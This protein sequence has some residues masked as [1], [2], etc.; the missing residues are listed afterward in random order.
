MAAGR[1]SVN[2]LCNRLGRCQEGNQHSRE[3]DRGRMSGGVLVVQSLRR[4]QDVKT[5]SHAL[6]YDWP[7][8]PLVPLLALR[9]HYPSV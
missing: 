6:G 2:P 3:Q 7:L 8:M 9:D 4:S 5:S 1:T